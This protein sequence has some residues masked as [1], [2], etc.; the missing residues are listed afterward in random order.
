[1]F[2]LLFLF[3]I[4]NWFFFCVMYCF[5]VRFFFVEMEEEKLIFDNLYYLL[6]DKNFIGIKK[7]WKDINK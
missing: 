3:L 1:M 7:K 4:F 2:F 5:Y 6:F